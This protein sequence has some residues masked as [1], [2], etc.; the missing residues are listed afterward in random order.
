M[1][2][3]D[4]YY[5][6]GDADSEPRAPLTGRIDVETCIVGGGLAGLATAL[7]L[8]RRGRKVCVLEARR[9]AWGA[10]GLN[11]GFVSPGYSAGY[12]AIAR[13]TGADD[14]KSLHR[15]SIEGAQAV[16]GQPRPAWPFQPRE[17]VDGIAFGV[18]LRGQFR[19]LMARRDWLERRN[20][21]IGSSS[22]PG[23]RSAR[24]W[25]PSATTRRSTTRTPFT[26]TRS[27]T[28]GA[29]HARSSGW[30]GPCSRSRRPRRSCRTGRV[31]SYPRRAARRAPN[32]S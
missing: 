1:T 4:T 22:A 2:Y 3:V 5:S 8:A 26:F 27:T 23:P 28:P 15:L 21:T 16:S 29:S 30:A 17:R 25:S 31:M 10:S 6:R 32:M 20:S 9:I 7:E 18:T 14:A 19:A 11:G 12:D 24:R 13:R